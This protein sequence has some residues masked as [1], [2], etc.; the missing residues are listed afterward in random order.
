MSHVIH[1]ADASGTER[2]IEISHPD[3]VFFPASEGHEELEKL[4]VARYYE[5]IADVMVPHL[6][7]RPLTLHRYP[8]GIEEGGFY[9]K[10]APDYFPRWIR[11]AEMEKEG[12]TVEHVLCED[13]ATLVYLANQGCVTP[14][15]WLSRADRPHHPD[16]L[17]FDLDP[18]AEKY[19]GG[20]VTG[21]ALEEL[22]WT[23]R[24][25][26]DLLA[27]LG[28]ESRP[29]TTGSRGY[30]VVV[31]LDRSA[32]YDEVRPFARRVA[33][34][35]AEDHP[36]RLTVEQRKEKRGDRVFVDWLRN[37]YAQLAVAPYALRARPGAPVATPLDWD[38]L[39]KVEPRKYRLHNLFRRLGQTE[40]PWADL[41]DESGTSIGQ[42]TKRLET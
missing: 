13:A 33:E 16:R 34:T 26:R 28:L 25:L 35:L 40:D 22:R 7:D 21:E 11:T 19:G 27:D 5:R 8:D 20:E 15:V 29:M 12:G 2:E 10:D 18:P 37:G 3:K 38:E 32:D 4:D 17:V 41:P 14:H 23:A 36:D 1:A 39:G 30:H 6:R 31:A 42:A 9:Q 24:R